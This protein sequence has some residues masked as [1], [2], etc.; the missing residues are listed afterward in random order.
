MSHQPEMQG[1]DAGPTGICVVSAVTS[2]LMVRPSSAKAAAIFRGPQFV[3][4]FDLFERRMV[5][6]MRHP[7]LVSIAPDSKNT[8]NHNDD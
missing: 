1:T 4:A 7:V 2:D 5:Q 6:G 3:A 8:V